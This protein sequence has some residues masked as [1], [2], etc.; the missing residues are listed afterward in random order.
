MRIR[1]AGPGDEAAVEEASRAFGSERPGDATSFLARPETL[2]LLAE[3]DRGKLAGQVYGH[4]LT[5]PDGQCTVLLYALDVVAAARRRGVGRALTEAFVGEAR[6]RGCTEVWVLTEPGNTAA[7]AT[8][9]SAGGR[10]EPDDSVM[11]VWPITGDPP[12]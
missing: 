8:Y 12:P 11:F 7:L 3:D 9:A 6:M 4:V 5:H 2:L 10:R 1:V